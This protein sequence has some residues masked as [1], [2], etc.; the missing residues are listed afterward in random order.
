MSVEGSWC[1]GWEERGLGT[2]AGVCQEDGDRKS[3][4]M[5]PQQALM[6]YYNPFHPD[7][8]SFGLSSCTEHDPRRAHSLNTQ[9]F[10][11]ILLY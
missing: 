9:P 1:R 6:N 3:N 7:D 5:A 4:C 8:D 10:C 11:D 2:V